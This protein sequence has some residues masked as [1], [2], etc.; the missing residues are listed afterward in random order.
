MKYLLEE[1]KVNANPETQE[2]IPFYIALN[3]NRQLV[4]LLLKNGVAYEQCV[5]Y[6]DKRTGEQLFKQVRYNDPHRKINEKFLLQFN[7]SKTNP[8]PQIIEQLKIINKEKFS[9]IL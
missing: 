4:D 6:L 3:N 1:A 5:G 8:E 2:R 9:P 7:F